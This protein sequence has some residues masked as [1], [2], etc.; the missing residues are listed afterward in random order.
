MDSDTDEEAVSWLPA[1]R[2]DFCRRFVSL[3]SYQF[4]SLTASLSLS[5]LQG[6]NK[7]DQPA[8]TVEELKYWLT[9]YDLNRLELYSKNLVD[10][11]LITDLLPTVACL[12]YLDKLKLSLSA[13]QSVTLLQRDYLVGLSLFSLFY[14]PFY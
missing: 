4:R 1:F 10:H 11:H 14:R 13:A 2:A 3:L 8:L 5:I 9:D 7:P 12:Q 6:R